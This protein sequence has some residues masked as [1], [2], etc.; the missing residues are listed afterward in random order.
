MKA[1]QAKREALLQQH[2][3]RMALKAKSRELKQSVKEQV[4]AALLMKFERHSHFK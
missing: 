4:E 2:Q 3:E 1:A